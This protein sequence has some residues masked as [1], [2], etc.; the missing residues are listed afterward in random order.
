MTPD[1]ILSAWASPGAREDEPHLMIDGVGH[2]FVQNA[3]DVSKNDPSIIRGKVY[4]P[5]VAT[6]TR[7]SESLA[8]AGFVGLYAIP[9]R[10]RR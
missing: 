3:D 10:L 9:D 6:R 1:S 4:G 5:P 7:S 8:A 2:P